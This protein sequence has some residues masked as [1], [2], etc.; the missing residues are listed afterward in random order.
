M[1]HNETLK[2]R[3]LNG[4]YYD[5]R[6]MAIDLTLSCYQPGGVTAGNFNIF[7]SDDRWNDDK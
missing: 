6:Q 2:E 1:N 4:V 7:T 3:R 5:K